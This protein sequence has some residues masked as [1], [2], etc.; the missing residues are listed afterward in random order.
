M[1]RIRL[2]T[3]RQTRRAAASVVVGASIV[4][5]AMGPATAAQAA[6]VGQRFTLNSI[7]TDRAWNVDR[8][9]TYTVTAI[10][11]HQPE[12]VDAA[13]YPHR[14]SGNDFYF[15]REGTTHGQG[16][17]QLAVTIQTKL[18]SHLYWNI[19]V[20]TG[21]TLHVIKIRVLAADDPRGDQTTGSTHHA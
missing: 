11:K 4:I 13:P 7:P 8:T 10:A 19:G 21:S 6:P 3:G 17:W 15:E 9:Q 1:N 20:R 18:R 14:P 12:Y 16:I 2:L 5:A